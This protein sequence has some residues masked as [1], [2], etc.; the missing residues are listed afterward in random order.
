MRQVYE[1]EKIQHTAWYLDL[2]SEAYYHSIFEVQKQTGLAF[3]FALIDPKKID[4]VINSKWMGENY[5]E[6]IWKNT[7][8]LAGTLKEELLVNLVTGRTERET[9]GII[10][11]RFAVG[12]KQVPQ[13]GAD[14]ILLS[15]GTDGYGK[16]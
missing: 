11:N 7:Q 9:A 6:R 5:S 4:R 13:A 16:L 8:T 14:R 12:D 1:Q 15:G 3:S 2:A 10:A